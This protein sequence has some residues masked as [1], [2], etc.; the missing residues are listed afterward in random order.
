MLIGCGFAIEHVEEWGPTE[1][2]VA[3]WPEMAS[4][5]ERPTFVLM[6]AHR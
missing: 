2:Q 4:D 1:E 5:W 6:S 3:E